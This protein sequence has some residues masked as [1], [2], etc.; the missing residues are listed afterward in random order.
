MTW[1]AKNSTSLYLPSMQHGP[2]ESLKTKKWNRPSVAFHASLRRLSRCRHCCWPIVTPAAWWRAKRTTMLAFASRQSVVAKGLC[3]TSLGMKPCEPYFVAQFTSPHSP[4]CL[5]A[6]HELRQAFGIAHAS[7][8]KM[9]K[10]CAE[11]LCVALPRKKLRS[12]ASDDAKLTGAS[13]S[14]SLTSID[15]SAT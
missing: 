7:S 14:R 12:E 1:W 10:D 8:R 15:H 9:R 2:R 13:S 3:D 5:G 4:H 11:G 6:A